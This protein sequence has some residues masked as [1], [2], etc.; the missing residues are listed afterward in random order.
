MLN[1]TALILFRS[2]ANK[3]ENRSIFYIKKQKLLG[4]C[5]VLNAG[6]FTGK[7]DNLKK[8]WINLLKKS[9]INDIP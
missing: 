5:D 9:R 8:Q 4:T 2:R 6:K 3:L 7:E 1:A